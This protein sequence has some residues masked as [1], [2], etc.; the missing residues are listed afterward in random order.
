MKILSQSHTDPKE[1]FI[2]R[3]L[4][5]IFQDAAPTYTVLSCTLHRKFSTV[6]LEVKDQYMKQSSCTIIALPDD[7]AIRLKTRRS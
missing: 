3:N 2:L 1:T 4:F 6:L 5:R 7:G